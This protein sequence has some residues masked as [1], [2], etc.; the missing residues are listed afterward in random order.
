MDQEKATVV[1]S[2]GVA[3]NYNEIDP[4][5]LP[6]P[7]TV[8]K[9]KDHRYVYDCSPCDICGYVTAVVLFLLTL[10]LGIVVIV[11]TA[12]GQENTSSSEGDCDCTDFTPSM[13]YGLGACLLLEVGMLVFL[14][15]FLLVIT[16][17][18]TEHIEKLFIAFSVFTVM[19]IILN[20]IGFFS[21]TI[22]AIVFVGEGG[23]CCSVTSII[24]ASL[25]VVM[26]TIKL[27][28]LTV[29]F[30]Y[31]AVQDC[32]CNTTTDFNSQTSS[33]GMTWTSPIN[34]NPP[35]LQLETTWGP[36]GGTRLVRAY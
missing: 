12:V 11:L 24:V 5:S 19:L 27:V 18:K 13:G 22:A 8:S 32:N 25:C 36:Y 4:S 21:T 20:G 1:I 23:S 6:Q 15:I 16:N 30:C 35:R 29:S 7:P 17:T 31:L 34:F 10:I 26:A 33:P 9:K 14:L 2:K 3:P 28:I